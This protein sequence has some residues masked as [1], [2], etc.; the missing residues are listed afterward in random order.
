MVF[1]TLETAC[2]VFQVNV[3]IYFMAQINRLILRPIWSSHSEEWL[4]KKKIFW[5]VKDISG[6]IGADAYTYQTNL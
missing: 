5:D 3:S 6:H 4:R 1:N 2:L